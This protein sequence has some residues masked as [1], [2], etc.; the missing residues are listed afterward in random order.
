M[1]YPHP[2]WS[3][4][5]PTS[6]QSSPPAAPSHAGSESMLL[7]ILVGP[8]LGELKSGQ[9]QLIAT[10]TAQTEV[11]RQI[12]AQMAANAS[13]LEVIPEKLEE[14]PEKIILP[15]VPPPV[16]WMDRPSVRDW[17]QI[18][19]ALVV[20]GAALSGKLPIKEVLPLIGKPFGF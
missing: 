5:P 1:S 15:I 19:I 6:H 12:H 10:M 16:K 13:L 18:A 11:L 3:G 4:Y 7:S 2:H 14:L 9:A 8:L 17:V 20:V